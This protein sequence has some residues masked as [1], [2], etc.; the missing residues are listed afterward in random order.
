[1]ARLWS[2]GFELNSLT[3]AVEFLVPAST[4]LTIDATTKRSGSYALRHN[5]LTAG[6][7]EHRWR[8]ANGDDNIFVRFYLRIAALP[9]NTQTIFQ[10]LNSSN[11]VQAEVRMISGGNLQLFNASAQVGSNSSA[12]NTGTWYRVEIQYNSTNAAGS[13]ILTARIDGT[14]FA[15]SSSESLGTVQK[16][17]LGSM[18]TITGTTPDLYFDDVGINDNTGSFQNSW[19]ENGKIIHLKPN[20][21]GDTNQWFSEQNNQNSIT[22]DADSSA[23]PASA[24]SFTWSH[25]VANQS[26]RILIVGIAYNT[27]NDD[28]PVTNTVKF[29][30]NEN[31]VL[32]QRSSFIDINNKSWVAVELWYLVNPTATTANI[33]VT[34]SGTAKTV[35]GAGSWYGVNQTYPIGFINNG[36]NDSLNMG[37][38]ASG[39]EKG[40]TKNS[41]CVLVAGA[42]SDPTATAGA[43][44]VEV[45]N[46]T[47]G[48]GSAATRVRG[49]LGYADAVGDTATSKTIT[50]ALSTQQK[51]TRVSIFLHP[52]FP[53]NPYQDVD[54]ETPNTSDYLQAG[55]FGAPNM[56]NAEQLF[57]LEPTPAEIASGNTIKVVQ[58]GGRWAHNVT[59][60]GSS[61][62]KLEILKDTGQTI[63]Q[64]AAISVTGTPWLTNN[65]ATLLNYLLTLYDLPGADENLW[66]KA[67][68]D[69]AQIGAKYTVDTNL[70]S[71]WLTT[72]WLLVEHVPGGNAFTQ[73]LSEAVILTE[74][75]V[76]QAGKAQNEIVLISDLTTRDT[77]RLFS[78]VV[79][80]ADTI[81]K[82][83]QKTFLEIVLIADSLIGQ[84]QKNLA[85]LLPL[86]M[87]CSLNQRSSE[88][89]PR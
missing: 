86:L 51:S 62:F 87:P 82:Q 16:F 25:T 9:S 10:I 41:L 38:G 4:G 65:S 77:T 70:R 32:A 75:A 17:R 74:A 1:M 14:D 31:F 80:I 76:R 5:S 20:A 39:G 6:Y 42:E 40:S 69:T 52:L 59:V 19:L 48:G 28:T 23:T 35:C 37:N 79:A 43:N 88:L 83:A 57:N 24:S 29:N 8:S 73:T 36:G 12:L 26:N 13:D 33:V 58:V 15:T 44:T 84:A 30:T 11:T 3:D 72:I 56:V 18:A 68:L 21:N 49:C 71:I 55:D 66:T 22:H 7:V 81:S 60:G 61:Q 64:S 45:F 89:S 54:E 85:K 34:L 50:W 63:E 46:L 53:S 78:E 27:N 67:L 47:M 2:C